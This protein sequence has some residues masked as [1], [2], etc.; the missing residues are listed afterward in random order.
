MSIVEKTLRKLDVAQQESGRTTFQ[1]IEHF[2]LPEP[3]QSFLSLRVVVLLGLAVGASLV[4]GVI[5][6]IG[7]VPGGIPAVTPVDPLV[8]EASTV[9]QL[10]SSDLVAPASVAMG[11]QT[12]AAHAPA[13][14][15]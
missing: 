5:L 14:G 8:K 3:P 13:N 15:A 7:K 1:T 10:P 9:K 4:V 6:F 12:S 11:K 2:R